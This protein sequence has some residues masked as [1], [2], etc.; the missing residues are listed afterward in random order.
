MVLFQAAQAASFDCR[1]AATKIE[2]L[3]CSDDKLS[4][5]DEKLNSAY[6]TALQDDGQAIAIRQ[7]QKQ[8]IKERNS[9]FDATCV[10]NVYETRL[11]ALSSFGE[12]AKIS[13]AKEPASAF[14]AEIGKLKRTVESEIKGAHQTFYTYAL[15][16]Y[17]LYGEGTSVSEF[18]NIDIDGDGKN[19]YVQMGCS[20]S[21]VLPSDP[22]MLSVKLSSGEEFDFEGWDIRLMK[23]RSKFYVIAHH[24]DE[25]RY[26][27]F[28][29]SPNP[30]EGVIYHPEVA[31][32]IKYELYLL[33]GSGTT[34][35]C[36]N[37]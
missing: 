7:T 31:A 19:D 26:K 34:L 29:E 32:A 37:L 14:C 3:I 17:Y 16:K 13:L 27:L 23:Y 21:T 22:C 12:S 8:W 4:K 28:T 30:D 10:K 18:R 20:A 9:C 35:V 2:K 6:K 33:N 36:K 1:K 25:A 5:L 24:D 11:V 15:D